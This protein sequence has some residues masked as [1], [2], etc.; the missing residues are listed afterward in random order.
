MTGTSS[1]ISGENSRMALKIQNLINCGA[2]QFGKWGSLATLALDKTSE[3][4][5][6]QSEPRAVEFLPGR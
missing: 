3:S 6:K 2:Q 1:M 4:K 5:Y